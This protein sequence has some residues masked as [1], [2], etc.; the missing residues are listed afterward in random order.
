[1][2]DGLQEAPVVM[3]LSDLDQIPPTNLA[4]D[5]V[6]LGDDSI[7]PVLPLLGIAALVVWVAFKTSSPRSALSG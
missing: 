3:T 5:P 4:K 6:K 7:G 2:P 1:M